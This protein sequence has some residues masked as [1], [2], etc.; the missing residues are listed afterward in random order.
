MQVL[1]QNHGRPVR[2]EGRKIV[3]QVDQRTTAQLPAIVKYAAQMR[4]VAERE[5]KQMADDVGSHSRPLGHPQYL[6]QLALELVPHHRRRVAILD[7]ESKGEQV[8]QERIR[9]M[10]RGR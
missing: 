3:A 8:M 1:E 10:L 4:A 9:L 7:L 6:V 2:R 5:A